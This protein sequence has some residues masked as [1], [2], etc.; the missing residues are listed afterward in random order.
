MKKSMQRFGGAVEEILKK[1]ASTAGSDISVAD[2]GTREA[3]LDSWA[4][5]LSDHASY[6]RSAGK[7]LGA[8]VVLAYVPDT[9][10]FT[11]AHNWT[12]RRML[13]V[14]SQDDLSGVLAAGTSESGGCVHPQRF[15]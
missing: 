13:G 8:P 10:A 11:E 1:V 14:N 15:K 9:G 6:L 2:A 12:V 3:F 5:K 4:G 7:L